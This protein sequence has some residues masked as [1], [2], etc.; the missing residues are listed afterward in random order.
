VN[1][2]A[3]M[4]GAALGVIAYVVAVAVGLLS[5]VPAVIVLLRAALAAGGGYVLGR[6]LGHVILQ[7]FLD[8]VAETRSRQSGAG[9]GSGK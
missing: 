5:G 7:A 8:E 2:L 9:D 3:R 1:D 6:L 4:T